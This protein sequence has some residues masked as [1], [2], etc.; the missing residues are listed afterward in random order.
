MLVFISEI[1]SF[2]ISISQFPLHPIENGYV[3][4]PNLT[5]TNLLKVILSFRKIFHD[6]AKL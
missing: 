2:I 5:I 3:C 1:G 6:N 4:S